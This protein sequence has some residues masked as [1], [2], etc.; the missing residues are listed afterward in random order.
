MG[1]LVEDL[2][3]LAELDRGRPLLAE[4]V[5][6]HRICAD[7]VDDNNAFNHEHTLTMGPGREVV[8]LGDP[9]RLTQVAHN[10]VRNALVHTPP[11]TNVRVSVRAERGMG[12]LRV[13][14][15][16]PGMDPATAARVFDRFYRQDPGRSGHGTG[17]GLA[18]VRAI[19]IALGGTAEVEQAGPGRGATVLVRIP[20]APKTERPTT[21]APATFLPQVR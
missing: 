13:S 20:L 14:D 10:L 1:G 12:V 18:I 6:L 9:E 2:L 21:Q 3:L 16:G 5:G 15:N 17:L 8:V 19:A 7:V 11:G 4:P